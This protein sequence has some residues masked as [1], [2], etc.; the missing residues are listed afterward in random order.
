MNLAP[1]SPTND[2]MDRLEAIVATIIGKDADKKETAA[3]KA[4]LVK[5]ISLE[6]GSYRQ[7]VEA[8]I[9]ERKYKP[10]VDKGY[11]LREWLQLKMRFLTRKQKEEFP[12]FLATVKRVREDK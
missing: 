1:Q 3:K 8:W 2:L 4:A 11:W 12:G 5:E 6:T 7:Q 10:N 9:F